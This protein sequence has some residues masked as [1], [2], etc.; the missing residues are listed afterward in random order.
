MSSDIADPTDGAGQGSLV[1]RRQHLRASVARGP[2]EIRARGLAMRPYLRPG[3]RVR[4]EARPPRRGD[5]VLVCLDERMVLQRLVRLRGDMGLIR[6]DGAGSVDAW[7]HR[8][9]ILAVAT[10]RQRAQQ[11]PGRW[12]RLDHPVARARG[13][14]TGRA[15]QASRNWLAYGWPHA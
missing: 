12:A 7:V 10:A 1:S 3:D 2:I 11:G 9:Q 8:D 5:I 13:L 14:A 6:A 4:L 15:R